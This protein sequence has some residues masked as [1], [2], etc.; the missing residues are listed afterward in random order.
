MSGADKIIAEVWRRFYT[1]AD[2]TARGHLYSAIRRIDTL[3]Q[4]T[5]ESHR[6]LFEMGAQAG[7]VACQLALEIM[8]LEEQ[9]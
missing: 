4:A 1:E 7:N 3:T 8:N 5:M 9:I 6:R 2:P